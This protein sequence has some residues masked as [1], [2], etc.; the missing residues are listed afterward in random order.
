MKVRLIPF[1]N[2]HHEKKTSFVLAYM[3]SAHYASKVTSYL[4]AQN[5]EYV[6]SRRMLLMFH[7]YEQLKDSGHFTK[8]NTPIDQI[9]P[10][11]FANLS[12]YG[13]TSVKNMHRSREKQLWRALT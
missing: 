7:R 3:A 9:H 10:Q 1:I 12:A 8:P 2:K 6:Q 13:K 4:D 11:P 5:I